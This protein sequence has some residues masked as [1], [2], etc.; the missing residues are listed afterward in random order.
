M[1]YREGES[2]QA[3]Q[4]GCSMQL[5]QIPL[6]DGKENFSGCF[7]TLAVFLGRLVSSTPGVVVIPFVSF[8]FNFIGFSGVC[9][10]L[11]DCYMHVLL[12]IM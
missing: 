2:R 3:V 1:L 4:S 12:R 5:T 11:L 7:S 6:E 10:L 9:A 8:S